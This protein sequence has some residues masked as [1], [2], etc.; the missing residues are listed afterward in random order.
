[1]PTA[2]PLGCPIVSPG[3]VG[4][5][6]LVPMG[7]EKA[8]TRGIM[9]R[10]REGGMRKMAQER[11]EQERK[12]WTFFKMKQLKKRGNAYSMKKA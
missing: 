8:R 11:E 9:G 1:M 6:S 5:P 10:P 12:S 2:V 7:W 3:A 4:Y